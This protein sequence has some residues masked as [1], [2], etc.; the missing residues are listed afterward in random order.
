MK[1]IKSIYFD[2]N[3]VEHIQHIADQEQRSFSGQIKLLLNLGLL[4]YAAD[5]GITEQ[6]PETGAGKTA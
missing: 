5:Y 3:M 6:H 2:S 1:I 4:H